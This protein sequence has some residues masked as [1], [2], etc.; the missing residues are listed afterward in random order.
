MAPVTHSL[1][2]LALSV[3]A[4]ASSARA[5]SSSSDL[6]NEGLFD[7]SIAETVYSV[8]DELLPPPQP[9][10]YD[11]L[12]LD[13]RSTLF[14]RI[15][16]G[17]DAARVRAARFGKRATPSA[18]AGLLH[19]RK[20]DNANIAC[21]STSDCGS[22]VP[23]TNG[24]AKC[25]KNRGICITECNDG[26]ELDSPY[27][28]ECVSTSASSTTSKAWDGASKFMN[29]GVTGVSAMQATLVDDDH[30][31]IY[32]KAENNAL[33]D[34]SGGSAWGS[35][36]TISTKAVRALNLK[37]NSFC[38]GGGW[39]SNGTLVNLGGNP[40]QT[41]INDEAEDGLMGIRLFTPCT[42]DKCDVYENPS[43]IRLTSNRWYPSST[44]LYD[45]SL[46]IAGG[47]IA[48]GYNNQEA[49]DNP[50]MEFYPP[51]GDGL[52]FYSQFL[53][54]ALDSNLYPIMYTLPSGELFIAA[55]RIAMIYNWETGNSALR[56]F[57]ATSRLTFPPPTEHRKALPGGVTVTYPA[58]AA[59]ALLPMTIANNWTPS[60]LFCGGTTADLDA[61]P[62]KMSATYPASKQCSRMEL[63]TAGFKAGWSTF[64][65]PMGRVMSDAI[66]M[67]DG[68]V[69]I[70][71]GAQDGIAGYGNVKDEVGAS[72]S[73]T[74]AKTPILYDPLAET[75]NEWTTGFPAGSS[76]RLYH[77][78]ATLL[79]DG[80]VWIAGSNPN[81]G[82]STVTYKTHYDVEI[83]KPPYFSLS[84]P[85]FTGAPTNLLYGKTTVLTVNLPSGTKT[86]TAAVIDIGY[87]THGV[88]MSHRYVELRT[89]LSG[90]KLTIKGPLSTG[91]Y[92]PGPG[93]LYIL[94]D[95]VPSVGTK[96]MVGPGNQPPVS[97]SAIKNM[98]AKTG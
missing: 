30:I 33:K 43:R 1:S 9:A 38:A 93:W 20:T 69:L 60:I 3:L 95:G 87:S 92:P 82:V 64:N 57:P 76:E 63:S 26:Y 21:S 80:S 25:N 39:L 52:Q 37:T 2:I 12:S 59:S 19:R 97:Q 32:D 65:M 44:R 46:L 36:Y 49:T 50:T 24:S 17:N 75:G 53:H 42:N 35:V 7:A 23:F 34:A 55:N 22:Y 29:K 4:L 66:L 67:P 83:F 10:D 85:S 27:G 61:D 72:N 94:A 78:S 8:E 16:D 98:L 86:V 77:S 47:M 18:H 40:Q 14:E 13:E 31:V 71:N 88:H 6:T 56:A 79:P 68:K 74:P 81:D 54:D 62:S 5:L 90:N 11:L 28:S 89:A 41:Y 73:K 15:V 45:G 48:G 58:S 96:V 84:R 91:I 70:I 51:K